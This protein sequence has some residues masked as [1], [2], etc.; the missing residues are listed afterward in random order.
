MLKTTKTQ[1][2]HFPRQDTAE[3]TPTARVSKMDFGYVGVLWIGVGLC[4]VGFQL[5]RI[6]QASGVN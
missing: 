1:R 4:L 3:G 6:G 2:L 5:R